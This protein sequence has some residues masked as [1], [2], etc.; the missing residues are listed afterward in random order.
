MTAWEKQRSRSAGV[1][2]APALLLLATF[3]L[4]PLIRAVGWS[5]TN[6]DLLVPEASTW[7]GGLNYSSLLRDPRFE[8]A[9]ANTAGFALI[10]V[11]VQTVLAFLCALW[12]NRPERAWRWLRAVFFL[13]VI[14]SMP[15]LAVL[16]TI[17]YQPMQGSEGGLINSTLAWVGL[18]TRAWLTD[19]DWALPA[20]AFMSVWQGLGLQ[21]MVFLAGLQTV[22]R[23]L[24]EAAR[25]DGANA[26][27]RTW[28]VT[29][30]ALRNT[31]IFVVTVTTILAFRLFVQPYLMT[32]GGPQN[33]TLSLV[34]SIYELTFLNQ[35][36]GRAC[37]AAVLFL[38]LVGALTGLQRW[39]VKEER[40]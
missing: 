17:L 37:A 14:V 35:E 25:I 24:L 32:H 23:E 38:V 34:Q 29:L 39:L 40:S 2:L 8:R 11:P 28:A 36:L 26:W 33:R 22:P 21:M 15:V 12:V 10:I 9:F 5:F 16:W 30:P 3:V 6:A 13:P 4:W 19:P 7:T 20:L 18:P 1:F 31:M 27:Q